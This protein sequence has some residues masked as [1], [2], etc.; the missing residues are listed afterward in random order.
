MKLFARP[1]DDLLWRIEGTPSFFEFE[2]GLNEPFFPL[3][4]EMVFN[5]LAGAL[6]R[7]TKEVWPQY[8]DAKIILYRGSANFSSHF[9]WSENQEANFALWKEDRPTLDEA[10]LK[11]L[12]C[13]EAYLAYFQMLAHKLPDEQPITLILDMENT[14]TLA[15]GIQLLSPERFEHFQVEGF[16]FQST[17]GICFP[18]DSECSSDVLQELNAFMH[19]LPHFRPVYETHLTEQWDGLDTIYVLP[20]ALTERGKRKLKGFEAAG[21]V[22]MGLEFLCNGKKVT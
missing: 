2:L 1:Q 11:R 5:A 9:L 3:E 7:F 12:F 20:N 4:D 15:E 22:V 16:H 17:M 19:T 21:G 18:P 6:T 10:Q 8:P 13:A 14:G